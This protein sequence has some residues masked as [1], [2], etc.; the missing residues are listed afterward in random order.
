MLIPT[1]P[2]IHLA[3]AFAARERGE[4][5]GAAAAEL[6]GIADKSLSDAIALDTSKHPEEL[7]YQ[8]V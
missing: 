2:I 6:F 5:G 3:T 1:L 4:T 8:A 7:I